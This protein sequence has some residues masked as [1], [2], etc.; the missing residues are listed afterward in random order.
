LAATVTR[1]TASPDGRPADPQDPA[2]IDMTHTPAKMD[3]HTT[4]EVVLTPSMEEGSAVY[5]QL[6]ELLDCSAVLPEDWEEL[7][8]L[9][10]A[11]VCESETV[12]DLI[13][14]LVKHKLLTAFQAK[15]VRAGRTKDILLGAYR[16][17]DVLGRGGMG[18]VYLGEHIH[19]RRRVAIK[20]TAHCREKN[21][22]LVHRFYAEARSVA[23]LRHPNIVGCLDA[24]RHIGGGGATDD[25]TDYFVMEFV[26]GQD[27][28]T[29]IRS[30]GPL[31]V[32]RTADIFRQVADALAE[33]H[34][35][36]LVHR[37][38]K[39]SNILIT[40]EF[41]A[42][43]LDFGLALHPK[44]ALT[45]PGT[46]LGTV[47]YMA[48]EQAR[49]PHSVDGRADLF[50]LGA[51]MFWA[52]TGREPFPE[53]GNPL[54]DLTRR[55]TAA[56]PDVR[57]A[58]PELPV[59][60]AEILQQLLHTDPDRRFPSA[61]A[62]STALEPFTRFTPPARSKDGMNRTQV[63]VVDSDPN[64]RGMIAGLLGEEFDVAD[65]ATAP[66]ART[67]LEKHAFDLIVL[68]AT[69]DKGSAQELITAVRKADAER[70]AMILVVSGTVPVAVLSGLVSVG[71]DDF[72]TKPFTPAELRSR[73]RALLGRRDTVHG[74]RVLT[75]ETMR[76]ASNG[77]H[78]VP[79]IQTPG[80]QA[81]PAPSANP[82]DLMTVTVSRLL[83]ETGYLAPGF[84]SRV[85]RYVR[86]MA[87][88]VEGSGEYLRLKD[89]TYTTMLAASSSLYDIG[90]LVIP[91]GLSLKPGKLDDDERQVIETHPSAG[92]D[93]IAGLA[94]KFPTET[95]CV[96]MAVELIRGHHERWDGTGYPDR[97]AAAEIP[98]SS[99]VVSIASVYD[100]LRSR[101]PYRP[102]LTH[103]RALRTLTAECPGRFDPTLLAAFL[104]GAPRIEQ[105]FNEYPV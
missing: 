34:K 73:I 72:M 104:A 53:S 41:Q 45:E 94:D 92:A 99:R 8:A 46:L 85:A 18:V 100:S 38:L 60:M 95:G 68:D 35:H 90:L 62:V 93:V 15:L 71:A 103:T 91:G 86:T 88:A 23:R 67:Y 39:P 55:L 81:M 48:P 30:G 84:R 87:Q 10:K 89:Q 77:V 76:F 54:S 78:R 101:R 66:D 96:S 12:D 43:L 42:K 65:A 36:G 24:G 58:R 13:G 98:L 26:P 52:L 83:V 22:R 17:L 6:G 2:E 31:T 3:P 7:S 14:H 1:P 27:L 44:H 16:L 5:R 57:L 75:M 74:R 28:D 32:P 70:S 25:G 61:E 4:A 47:G 102:A 80:P 49:D 51:S 29:L 19:L 63:L 59:D 56:P 50:S 20:I 40:P 105:I 37:D 69:P 64:S 11:E 82:W 9:S 21:P 97:I 79:V 33:A